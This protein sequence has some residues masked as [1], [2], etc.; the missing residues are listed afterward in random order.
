MKKGEIMLMIVLVS[1]VSIMNIVSAVPEDV[2]NPIFHPINY[3]EIPTVNSSDYW[4]TDIGSLGTVNPTQFDNINQTLNID[5]SWLDSFGNGFWLALDGSN[6]PTSEIDWG[7][8]SLV[9]VSFAEAINVN[10]INDLNVTR[11]IIGSGKLI[12]GIPN[13]SLCNEVAEGGICI[14]GQ[15]TFNASVT[16]LSNPTGFSFSV[17]NDRSQVNVLDRINFQ[18][19]YEEENRLFCDPTEGNFTSA[20][21]VDGIFILFSIPSFF[22]YNF[23]IIDIIN[24]TCV[25]V[26]PLGLGTVDPASDFIN[27]SYFQADSAIFTVANGRKGGTGI[28]NIGENEDEEFIINALN[29]TGPDNFVVRVIAGV[30]DIF[31]TIIDSDSNGQRNLVNLLS[32]MESE[33]EVVG[34]V[35]SNTIISAD[36]S[37]HIDGDY[38]GLKI[39]LLDTGT[40]VSKTALE[41]S[42]EFDTIIEVTEDIDLER[43]YYDNASTTADITS[44]VNDSTTSIT[45]FDVNGSILYLGNEENFTK[46]IISVENESSDNL[47]FIFFYCNESSEWQELN[48][49]DNTAGLTHSGVIEFTNPLNR[50]TCNQEI[51]DTPFPDTTNHTYIAIQRTEDLVSLPPTVRTVRSQKDSSKFVIGNNGLTEADFAMGFINEEFQEAGAITH[52]FE[53][54]NIAG[55]ILTNLWMQTGKNFSYSGIGNSFGVIPNYIGKDNFTDG[56]KINMT[57]LTNYPLLCS[58]FGVDC[59]FNADTRGNAI[60][61]IPGGPLLWTMGDFEVWQSV[62]IHKGISVEGSAIFNM[63]ENDFD[64]NNGSLHIATPVT[65]QKGFTAGDSVIKFT[66]TFAAT[67]GIFTNLQT[68]LGD[69]TS[70]INTVNCDGGQCAQG[71][72]AGGGLVEMQ[73][74][75][76]T[77]DINETTLSFVYSLANLIGSGEFSI[78]VNNNVGSGDVVIFSDT[79]DDVTKS[80][81][82]ISLP[83]SMNNQSLISITVI[84]DIASA[85]RPARQ[86]FI[87]TMKLNGTAITTT[88]I[89]VSGF[90]GVIKFGDGTLAP[91]GFPERGIIF[92]ASGDTIIFRGNATFENIIEQT[93]SITNS[94]SLNGTNIFD[95]ADVVTSP[96]FPEYFLL[97]GSSVMQAN[98]DFG[99]FNVTNISDGDFSNNI[100][101]G[102][103]VTLDSGA[104]FWSNTTCAFIS[105]PNGGFVLEVCD[106]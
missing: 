16:L 51:D 80:S 28:F 41:I 43:V 27:A 23:V 20:D 14:N 78:E 11:N 67:L 69:W 58:T 95:W 38:T 32:L 46:I 100:D 36:L 17:L 47:D 39:D 105:S 3:S 44:Q 29:A 64:I 82:V 34:S 99:G 6:S 45:L 103:N 9:N 93:L 104:K 96:L 10:V 7:N 62:K 26:I 25:T 54:K 37:N 33:E 30:D 31:N 101:V 55:E 24:S 73:T 63:E 65:F 53:S 77:L 8:Q 88:L 61:L 42:T 76:S 74:N 56:G 66:E 2:P 68:D 1:M 18:T 50:G 15:S 83:S 98:A 87:D 86:C 97:N 102:N 5:E 21:L 92:N 12:M 13:I 84:C 48:A 40:N 71:T 72:G 52:Y 106:P 57:K 85:N 49:S 19:T 70:V 91:D 4:V 75:I 90:D 35:L 60:D 94:I 79:T 81:Q 89:N 22:G 59:S